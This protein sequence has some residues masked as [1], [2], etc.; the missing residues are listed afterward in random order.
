M[1]EIDQYKEAMQKARSELIDDLS[2]REFIISAG[3]GVSEPTGILL[4]KELLKALDAKQPTGVDIDKTK[5]YNY[6]SIAQ[7]TFRGFEENGE[8]AEYKKAIQ[9]KVKSTKIP[10]TPTQIEMILASNGK[11]VTTNFDDTFES[12][13]QAL[14]RQGTIR[15]EFTSQALPRLCSKNV[16]DENHITY[17]HGKF[18]ELEDEIIFKTTDYDKHYPSL[19]GG[20]ESLVEK[21]LSY[22]YLRSDVAIVFVGFSFR[23]KYISRTLERIN[24]IIKTEKPEILSNIKHYAILENKIAENADFLESE[25][26]ELFAE[27]KLTQQELEA[28][29]IKL[30]RYESGKHK[31]IYDVFVDIN[32]KRDKQQVLIKPKE[33]ANEI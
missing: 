8:V 21:L 29:N 27:M 26:K 28:I 1:S 19:N 15:S 30:L 16:E 24:N 2:Q 13:F 10:H 17:L 6:P 7:M 25:V 11:I 33:Q 22:L 14:K 5:E 18:D 32:K 31:E 9:E 20:Q 4:W 12:A 23:D 3:A